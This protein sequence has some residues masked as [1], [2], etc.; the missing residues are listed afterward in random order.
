MAHLPDKITIFK[1][2]IEAQAQTS[3]DVREL[4]RIVVWHEIAH[5]F[6]FN[7]D[8]VRKLERRWRKNLDKK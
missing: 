6:G 4:T 3:E 1:P 2:I 8:E 7:E 5:H